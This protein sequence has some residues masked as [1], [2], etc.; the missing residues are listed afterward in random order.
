MIP[1][2]SSLSSTSPAI[3]S[4]KAPIL[5]LMDKK[6]DLSLSVAVVNAHAVGSQA[7]KQDDHVSAKGDAKPIVDDKSK[8]AKV[9][10]TADTNVVIRFCLRLSKEKMAELIER[11]R[12]ENMPKATQLDMIRR[13][14]GGLT[15]E[16]L[17]EIMKTWRQ[18]AKEEKINALPRRKTMDVGAQ[19]EITEAA[20]VRI[21]RPVGFESLLKGSQINVV[22]T[23]L[24]ELRDSDVHRIV[25]KWHGGF[26][27]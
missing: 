22:R 16:D 12:W 27:K 9:K 20:L 4:P 5:L 24:T 6:A 15:F 17:G 13:S 2:D 3:A 25:E 10:G 23:A 19:V 21:L 7:P 14:L 11:G 8:A 18:R 1:K 26:G